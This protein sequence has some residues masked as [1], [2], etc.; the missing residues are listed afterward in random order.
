MKYHANV[1]EIS[2]FSEIIRYKRKNNTLEKKGFARK[3]PLHLLPASPRTVKQAYFKQS[4][5][6]A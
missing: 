6:F 5:R 3:F 1:K 4:C 2:R